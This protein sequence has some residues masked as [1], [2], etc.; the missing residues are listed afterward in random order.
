MPAQS[1]AARFWS[2]VDRSAG[3]DGCWPYRG[4]LVRGYGR[5]VLSWDRP[6]NGA[7]VKIVRAHRYAFRL[8]RGR[9]PLPG[10]DLCHRCDNRACCNP[11][12]LWEGTRRDNMQDASRKGRLR[13]VSPTLPSEA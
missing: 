10:L 4:A 8:A 12:H 1:T 13:R 3:P 7:R 6:G 5:F 9:D 2:K 11:A